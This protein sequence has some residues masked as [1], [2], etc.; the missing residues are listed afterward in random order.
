M[1]RKQIQLSSLIAIGIFMI[2]IGFLSI[3]RPQSF[4]TLFYYGLS[5]GL[6]LIG[7][8]TMISAFLAKGKQDYKFSSFIDGLSYFVAGLI[9]YENPLDVLSISPYV[10][11]GYCILKAV[12]CGFNFYVHYTDHLKGQLMVLCETLFYILFGLALIINPL[13]RGKFVLDIMGI[14]F[15]CFGIVQLGNF[16]QVLFPNLRTKRLKM[17]LPIFMNFLLPKKLVHL[18]N[19]MLNEKDPMN[20]VLAPI[21]KE[22][23]PYDMEILIHLGANGFDSVGHVDIAF[24]DIIISYGCHDHHNTSF[25]GALGPGVIH[26]NE[27]TKY[28]N[29]V[30]NERN[31]Q[32]V[33][34]GVHLTPN[35][36]KAI[37]EALLEL[38]KRFEPWYSDQDKKERGEA[39][40][41]DCQNYA[42][43]LSSSCRSKFFKFTSGKF[44]TYF[45]MTTNCV[46]LVDTLLGKTGIDLWKINGIITP[47]SY[48]EFLNNEFVLPHSNVV[49][50]KI[51]TQENLS[52]LTEHP[53]L[54]NQIHDMQDPLSFIQN[55]IFE[56]V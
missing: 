46:L 26:F 5:I 42:S 21:K 48:Y 33:G 7:F 23:T 4:I 30:I 20:H 14:Y 12:I 55:H 11:G 51:Y 41:G 34:F 52:M 8:Y 29:F 10:I 38:A 54:V 6:P 25:G 43:K 40:Q 3:L 32:L 44:K 36:K 56:E 24:R 18:I 49:F 19:R 53:D 50:R 27:K 16:I 15:I 13:Y 37:K 28:L 47:G 31:K 17:T 9:I 22:D 2:Y 39:Y 1:L 45:I 35:Q